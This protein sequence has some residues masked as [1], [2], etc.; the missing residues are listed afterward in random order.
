ML[1]IAELQRLSQLDFV[2]ID[3]TQLVDI[4][5]IDIDPDA[6]AEERLS[7]FI[8]KVGNPYLFCVGKVPV[9]VTFSQTEKSLDNVL[10][11]HFSNARKAL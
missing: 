11:S 5:G 1:T 2:D 7:Q 6:P 4:R 8:E 10:I 3:K 9:R